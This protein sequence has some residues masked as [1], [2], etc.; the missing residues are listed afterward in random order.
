MQILSS[1]RFAIFRLLI[2]LFG[3]G[4]AIVIAGWII[5]MAPPYPRQSGIGAIGGLMLGLA[6]MDR[7]Q[8]RRPSFANVALVVAMLLSLPFTVL[9]LAFGEVDMLAFMFHLDAG[10]AGVEIG[11]ASC[12]ERV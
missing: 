4:S 6:M 9:Y 2:S 1:D 7:S 8:L 10:V 5:L 12:R 3:F 11:R